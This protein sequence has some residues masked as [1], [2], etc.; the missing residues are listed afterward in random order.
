MPVGLGAGQLGAVLHYQLYDGLPL[1]E[2]WLTLTNTSPGPGQGEAVRWWPGALHCLHCCI[3]RVSVTSL[4][5]LAVNLEWAPACAGG[6]GGSPHPWV[7][8][9]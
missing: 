9:N 5:E 2:K 1:L 8:P 3:V 6:P 7:T 4:E